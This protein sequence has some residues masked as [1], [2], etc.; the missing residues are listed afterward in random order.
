MSFDISWDEVAKYAVASPQSI[1]RVVSILNRLPGP[2]PFRHGHRRA[3]RAGA[4]LCRLRF[5]G[6]GLAPVDPG[7]EPQGAQRQLRTPL[8]RGRRRVRAWKRP[9]C[10]ESTELRPTH[11]R[12]RIMSSRVRFAI[13]RRDSAARCV[14]RIA[15]DASGAVRPGRQRQRRSAQA[16][17]ET[18][19][20]GVRLRDARHRARFQSP[21]IRLVV[22]HDARHQTSF[23]RRTS[24]A[25][26]IPPSRACVRRGSASERSTP[27]S[28]GELQDPIRMGTFRCGS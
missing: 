28:L 4:L 12:H 19:L 27:T 26:T 13:V 3:R 8:R 18:E 25:R 10:N 1:A 24:S 21:S 2:V 15:L 11:G 14:P 6:A 7:R 20:R 16:S 9:T 5:V 22:R 23:V 17:N